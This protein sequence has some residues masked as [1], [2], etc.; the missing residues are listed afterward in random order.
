LVLF[1]LALL[2]L[3]STFFGTVTVGDR[4]KVI[5]SFGLF[6]ASLGTVL[7]VS[8]AGTNLLHKELARKTIYNIL[9]KAVPRHA[10]LLGKFL[11]VLATSAVLLLL[12]T[13]ALAIYLFPFS[14]G[15]NSSLFLAAAFL[16]C[17]VAIVSAAGIF[18]SAL[19][20]TPLLAGCFTF[21]TFLVGRSAEWI[22]AMADV[23]GVA[24]A[25]GSLLRLMYG[26]VPH[27][28]QMVVADEIVYGVLPS[29]AHLGW[30][31]A[32]AVGYSSLLLALA[33]LFFKRRDFN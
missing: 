7:F 8:I 31:I 19:V 15:F 30:S 24:P 28:H 20:V 11:G 13:L 6:G 23:E 27:L 33:A 9:G 17:E 29:V 4:G 26:I 18:F 16:L 14:G 25:V 2:V 21:A 3:T 10:F 12:M 1:F 32:Y 22:L 5:T